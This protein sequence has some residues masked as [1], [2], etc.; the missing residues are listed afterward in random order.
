MDTR[1]IAKAI[2]GEINSISWEPVGDDEDEEED[3]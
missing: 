2:Y 1:I 3:L